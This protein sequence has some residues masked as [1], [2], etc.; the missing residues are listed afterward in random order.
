VPESVNVPPLT[1]TKCQS[2]PDACSVI[3]SMP[4]VVLLNPLRG[5][6]RV[7][8]RFGAVVFSPSPDH[9][10]ADP[11]GRIGCPR[12]R[13]RC[14]SLVAMPVPAQDHIHIATYVR[15]V[16]IRPIQS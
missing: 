12:C 9:E 7:E 16:V 2:Y 8:D 3:L 10:L 13:L 15:N 14:E 6:L 1:G 5:C 4:K 11:L